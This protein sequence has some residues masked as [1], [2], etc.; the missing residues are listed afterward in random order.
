MGGVLVYPMSQHTPL[1]CPPQTI[2]LTVVRAPEVCDANRD[3]RRIGESQDES[4]GVMDVRM[5]RLETM[6]AEKA[7]K[8]ADEVAAQPDEVNGT[9]EGA[10]LIIQLSRSARERAEMQ[11]K[12]NPIHFSHHIQRAHLG[13]PTVHLTEHMEYP[14]AVPVRSTVLAAHHSQAPHPV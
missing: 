4:G 14:Y 11:L 2:R 7:V 12:S 9:A 8:P 3:P 13:T 10:D 1:E 5:N 6:F